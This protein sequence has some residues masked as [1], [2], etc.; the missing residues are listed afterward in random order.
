M[1]PKP[2]GEV[3]EE[4]TNLKS[5]STGLHPTLTSALDTAQFKSSCLIQALLTADIQ[6]GSQGKNLTKAL[7]VGAFYK[8]ANLDWTGTFPLRGRIQASSHPISQ[9][10]GFTRTLFLQDQAI[11]GPVVLGSVTSLSLPPCGN[12][13]GKS[14]PPFQAAGVGRLLT[15]LRGREE[16]VYRHGLH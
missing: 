10:T 5:T 9:G 12:S 4:P 1:L 11:T 2:C 3:G 7:A 6:S 13:G 8:Q 15:T 16:H 14:A